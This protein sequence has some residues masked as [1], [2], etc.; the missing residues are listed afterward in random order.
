M[1]RYSLVLP[2]EMWR[3]VVAGAESRGESFVSEVRRALRLYLLWRGG[4]V[5][6]RTADGSKLEVL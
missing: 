2:D 1:K 6:V 3:E 5:E 4:K